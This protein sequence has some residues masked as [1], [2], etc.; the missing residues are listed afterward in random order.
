M[1]EPPFSDERARKM[2]PQTMLDRLHAAAPALTPAERQLAAH[3]RRN[4]PVAGLASIT[5]LASAA[6]VSSPTVLRL[7]QKLSFRGYP[8]F[9]AA[10]RD[11]LEAQLVSPLAKHERWAGS[12]PEAHVLNRFAGAVAENVQ[13]TMAQVDPAEFDA[14]AALLADPG[15][16][17]WAV[18]GRITHTLA[19]YLC[20]HLSL[21]R[22]GV[23]LVPDAAT[24]WPPAILDM[25]QGDVLVAFDIR[26]YEPAVLTLTAMAADAGA[27]VILLTDQWLSPAAS[28]AVHVFAAHVEVPS[29][30]DSNMGLL[31][32]VETLLAAVQAQTH[33][34][35]RSRMARLE[36]LYGHSKTLRAR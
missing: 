3:L 20:V 17:V 2:Q 6:G 28:R 11:E 19:D 32:L 31:L 14:C 29:A 15:R 12:A 9:Q 27:E 16:R 23:Q 13:A 7:V 35:T 33:D 26:R 34:E 1:P 5:R 22:P 18:G 25:A 21:I 4:Y 36:E 10:L 8:E 24:G 30:W